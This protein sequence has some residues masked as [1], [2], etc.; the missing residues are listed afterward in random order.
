MP[1]WYDAER[2]RRILAAS[3]ST[4]PMCR[5]AV[6]LV[7]VIPVLACAQPQTGAG[8]SPGAADP[9]A[10]VRAVVAQLFDGMRARDTA[11][12]RATLHPAA[13]LQSVVRRGETHHIEEGDLDGFVAALGASTVTWDERLGDVEVRVDDGLA[14]AWMAYRFYAGETFSHC[15]VNAMQLALT[16]SGWQ[17]V[18]IMDTRRTGCE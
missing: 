7:L 13:R 15:G 16:T 6:L 2:R 10:A 3:L 5:A 17:I 1:D 18:Q 11:M 8:P 14:T 12:V 4:P 9:E